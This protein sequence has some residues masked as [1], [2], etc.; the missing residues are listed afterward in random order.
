[1][2]RFLSL[3][4]VILGLASGMLA[5]TDASPPLPGF[6]PMW[7]SSLSRIQKRQRTTRRRAGNQSPN[8]AAGQSEP[9]VEPK[10]RL[11]RGSVTFD[12]QTKDKDVHLAIT[13]L[14]SK[15]LIVHISS[16]FSLVH[17]GLPEYLGINPHETVTVELACSGFRPETCTDKAGGQ[18]FTLSAYATDAI[19]DDL[20]SQYRAL[21][22]ESALAERLKIDI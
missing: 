19:K 11:D 14:C 3:S 9:G 6:S 22:R 4:L 12:S 5:K 10:I 18:F 2:R 8:P 17:F 1:M 16:R 20:K 7:K 13:N 21:K 15:P